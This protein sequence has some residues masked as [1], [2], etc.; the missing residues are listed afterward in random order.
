MSEGGEGGGGGNGDGITTRIDDIVY[1]DNSSG[2]II[3]IINIM[4]GKQLVG[5]CK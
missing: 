3:N 2:T 4:S 5:G 1:I